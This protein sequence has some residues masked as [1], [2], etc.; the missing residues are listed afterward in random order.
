MGKRLKQGFY[1]RGGVIWVRTDPVERRART[2]GCRDPEAAYMWRAER[3]RI[4]ANP[5]YAASLTAKVGHWVTKTIDIKRAT[6]SAGTVN[7]YETKLGHFARVWGVELPLASID[8]DRV[9]AYIAQRREEGA[10]SNT[11]HRELTCLRQML[12]FA[13]RAKAFPTDLGE[14]MPVGFSSEYK[15]VTR[16][17]S[18]EDLPK[19]WKALRTD[20][21]R[22]WVA[23]ALVTG[24]DNADVERARPE[25][26]D[27][28]R[29]VVRVRGTKTGTRD[30][31]VPVQP[32]L[33]ELF[34]WAHA[35][36][37]V[38]WPRASKGLGDACRRA[39][40]PHLSPKD[41]RR[42]AGNL[43]AER[44]VDITSISRFLRH[45]SDAMARKVYTP[46]RAEA[47]GRVI[48]KQSGAD[49]LQSVDPSALDD[50]SEGDRR[51]QESCSVAP[52]GVEPGRHFWQRILSPE[53]EHQKPGFSREKQGVCG[54]EPD[55][56]GPIDVSDTLQDS[57]V[58]ALA[59]AAERLCHGLAPRAGGGAR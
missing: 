58:W 49:S 36:L 38:S 5:S 44:G 1:W 25:D 57:G 45:G 26:Y 56:N 13:K 34:E 9:D 32:H 15:P 51:Q 33:R 11:I 41:L 19:L 29:Q 35:R 23:F 37:P 59:F 6:K 21:R 30:A 16:T 7:M 10:K 28:A 40:I 27:A 47:L 17:L 42:T 8:A 53:S 14:V 50:D 22:A 43:M 18:M 31:E 48:A 4:A 20:E 55:T 12:R 3:E 52:P 2:T 24:A 46:V 54:P 39:G